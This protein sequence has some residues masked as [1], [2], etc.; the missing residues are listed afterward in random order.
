MANVK[1]KLKEDGFY[2]W[3]N[4]MNTKLHGEANAKVKGLVQVNLF[5]FKTTKES[6]LGVVYK[7]DVNDKGLMLN[8]CPWCGEKI[9]NKSKVKD[10]KE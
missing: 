6:C 1:C 3:C 5:N 10:K 7:R 2:E 9:L 8:L 4:G